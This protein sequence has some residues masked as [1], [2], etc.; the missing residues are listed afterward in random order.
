MNDPVR[1]PERWSD[2]QRFGAGGED[3]DGGHVGNL[4]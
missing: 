4:R 1:N 2:H 3:A